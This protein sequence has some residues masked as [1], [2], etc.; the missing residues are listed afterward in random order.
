[1]WWTKGEE[2]PGG[3]PNDYSCALEY[4]SV[5]GGN[6]RRALRV[7]LELVAAALGGASK[8]ASPDLTFGSSRRDP[9]VAP[10]TK[11]TGSNGRGG[12]FG[13]DYCFRELVVEYRPFLLDLLAFAK[14][15][16]IRRPITTA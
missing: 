16:L 4:N 8:F 11:H 3:R 1:M 15:L 13:E 7:M 2:L 10:R 14:N 12:G 9:C 5:D 6:K